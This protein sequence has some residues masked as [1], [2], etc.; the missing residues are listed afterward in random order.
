MKLS[1]KFLKNVV[2]VN[3]FQYVT[4]WDISEGSAQKLFFQIIDK[5]KEDLRYIPQDAPFV[6]KVT[7]LSIDD[8]AIIE[9]TAVQSFTDDKSIWEIELLATEVPNTGSAK[10]S[11]SE[12]GVEAKFKVEQAIVV[13][14][15]ND[16]GC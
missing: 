12:N 7:F 5:H 2:N 10:F 14:L 11:L 9:K 13:S 4:Q 15:L 3:T 16:G 8:D 6:V 1:A